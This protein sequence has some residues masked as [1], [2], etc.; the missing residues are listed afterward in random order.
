MP[1][2]AIDDGRIIPADTNILFNLSVTFRDPKYFKDPLVFDPE[3]FSPENL[4]AG[5][6]NPFNFVPFSAGPRN[7]VGQKYAILDMK[8]VVSKMLLNFELIPGGDEP[9]LTFQLILRTLNG[10]QLG[11]IPRVFPSI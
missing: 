8:T 10:I 3:R 6:M 11:L 7:C 4:A 2:L 5:K 1:I 9:I